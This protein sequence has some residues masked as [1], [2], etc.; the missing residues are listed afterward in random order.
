MTSA[1]PVPS[2]VAFR[3]VGVREVDEDE[4]RE[5]RRDLVAMLTAFEGHRGCTFTL[6][7]LAFPAL[8]DVHGGHIEVSVIVKIPAGMTGAVIEEIADDV[9]DVLNG[10][11]GLWTF[12][13]VTEASEL[14]N[15]LRPFDAH[16]FAEI[17]RREES[18]PGADLHAVDGARQVGQYL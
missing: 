2:A 11:P 13:R 15:I 16:Y 6:Q 17:S 5:T 12:E 18:L 14:E 4:L 3:L 10:P 9:S 8:D 1:T 7:W